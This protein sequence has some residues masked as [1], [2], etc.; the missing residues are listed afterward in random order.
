MAS[1]GAPLEA[2][3][4]GL[5]GLGPSTFLWESPVWGL[6]T[7]SLLLFVPLEM[8]SL[9][10]MTRIGIL[11]PFSGPPPLSDLAYLAPSLSLGTH[12]PLDSHASFLGCYGAQWLG[13]DLWS[14]ISHRQ[15]FK[16]FLTW[17]AALVT[18]IFCSYSLLSDSS[19]LSALNFS[20]HSTLH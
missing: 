9:T 8:K 3:F 17:D 18:W 10:R 11:P 16:Y 2:A 1:A 14:F 4:P 15:L 19:T 20:F 7:Q 6:S 13:T 5:R 12:L